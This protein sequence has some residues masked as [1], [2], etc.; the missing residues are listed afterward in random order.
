MAVIF[1][2]PLVITVMSCTLGNK[3]TA[4]SDVRPNLS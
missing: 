2:L 4:S 1:K 3:V